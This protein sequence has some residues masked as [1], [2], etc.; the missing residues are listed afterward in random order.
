MTA[1]IEANREL[2]NQINKNKDEYRQQQLIAKLGNN[3]KYYYNNNEYKITRKL[4]YS[5]ILEEKTLRK[6]LQMR[7]EKGVV[8]LTHAYQPTQIEKELL[9][10]THKFA[11]TPL[12]VDDHAN[13]I[14]FKKFATKI[15]KRV[16]DFYDQLASDPTANI[17][18]LATLQK[19]QAM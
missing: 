17:E 2:W 4:E 1:H 13:I 15:R 19:E 6:I 5:H 8:N 16:S 11:I 10:K 3:G 14:Q 12:E 7:E 18:E 9:A